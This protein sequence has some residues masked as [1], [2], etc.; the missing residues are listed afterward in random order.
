MSQP[1][2]EQWSPV[3][4]SKLR[5]AGISPGLRTRTAAGHPGA[6]TGAL[7]GEIN[8]I[9]ETSDAPDALHVLTEEALNDVTLKLKLK[10][11]FTTNQTLVLGER[12]L[13]R[14]EVQKELAAA[15]DAELGPKFLHI[16]VK[17]ADI[18]SVYFNT[19]SGRSLKFD[20]STEQRPRSA[21]TAA[22][23]DSPRKE[24]VPLAN[25]SLVVRGLVLEKGERLK[26]RE[27]ARKGPLHD[28]AVVHLVV[29]RTAKVSWSA[30]GNEFELS[31]SASDSAETVKRRAEAVSGLAFDSHQLVH[32]GEVLSSKSL[33]EYGVQKGS[34]LELVP[35]EPFV[36]ESMPE[37]SPLLSSPAHELFDGFQAARAGLKNGHAPKLASSGTG[38][39]Y[40][41]AGADGKPVAVFKP[42]DEEPLA[43]NNPKMHKGDSSGSSDHGL[44]RGIRP[45]EGAMREVA[46]FLLDHD[47]FAGVPPTALVS[48]HAGSEA[49]SDGA[50]VGSLQAFVEA[51]G[52]CEERGIS[53]FPVREVHKIALLD[54]RLGNC[55]RNGGNILV[56]KGADCSWELVPIDHGYVLP[57]SFQDISFEWLYWPQARA[58]FDEATLAYIEA[59]DAERD[60][61]ILAQHGLGIRPE[62]AR[63]LRVL[64][65][66]LKKAAARGMSPFDIGSI[67][68]REGMGKSPLEKLHSRATAQAAAA[69]PAASAEPLY[70]R[71]M[72]K[73]V[74]E[75]LEEAVLDQLPIGA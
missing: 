33:A 75:Y 70:L 72:D 44:R 31:I 39:S 55:D 38:G 42:L 47:H 68:C 16:V 67:M 61:A 27:L 60:L 57:D 9:I 34:V 8:V 1:A 12:E 22:L 50:K 53:A 40:F 17:L 59:L 69:G 41:I 5:A 56:R 58:T 14:Q 6:R 51:E 48:C 4:F 15:A 10:G 45:G 52:D 26:D 36:Q 29:R 21:L 65:A 2:V 25:N 63:V 28:S 37:G 71:C 20:Q 74:D 19:A 7:S 43:V 13:L 49:A 54:M 46:A 30:Q 35:Y 73:L 32:N 24:D 23:A 66:L 11:W 3:A 18:E 62:C 64:T